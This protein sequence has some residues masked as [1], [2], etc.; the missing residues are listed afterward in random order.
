LW[1]DGASK[2]R[3][4]ALPPGTKIDTTDPDFWIFPVGT[5]LWKE[6]SKDGIRVETRLVERASARDYRMV[7]YVWKPDQSD[8]VAAVDGQV[9]ALGTDHDVPSAS[10]CGTCHLNHPGRI[11]GFSAVQLDFDSAELSLETLRREDRLSTAVPS[12]KGSNLD[13][14]SMTALGTL[15]AN[16]G[17][18][19]N[20]NS[21]IPSRG[22]ELHL[23]VASLDAVTD[24][25]FYRTTVGVAAGSDPDG[26]TPGILVT[27]GD[28]VG[29][30][31]VHRMG[32]RSSFVAMPPLA[33]KSV[34]VAGLAAVSD[35]ISTLPHPSVRDQ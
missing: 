24:T 11:L 17:T 8:A 29:S 15:H 13:T 31:L 21:T 22:V 14:L 4:I 25:P 30:A 35:F 19:H 2:R 1:S 7:A 20:P 32:S 5:K 34:D 18:C 12:A 26:L 9:R 23:R 27:P 10:D 3:W 16:C 33:S 6:F 28:P